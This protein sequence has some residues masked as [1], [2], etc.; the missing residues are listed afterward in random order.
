MKKF[1]FV[2]LSLCLTFVSTGSASALTVYWDNGGDG[3]EWGDN[4]NWNVGTGLE[5]SNRTAVLNQAN[6]SDGVD[7]HY[8]LVGPNVAGI[9]FRGAGTDK[10]TLDNE[11]GVRLKLRNAGVNT[12]DNTNLTL[13][14]TIRGS[15]FSNGPLKF[16]AS[17]TSELSLNNYIEGPQGA[18]IVFSTT[19]SGRLFIG[20]Y[21][22]TYGRIIFDGTGSDMRFTNNFKTRYASI[23][24]HPK[25]YLRGDFGHVTIVETGNALANTCV[26]V[27]GGLEVRSRGILRLSIG[28]PAS[29]LEYTRMNVNGPVKL[30]AGSKLGLV[31]GES[32]TLADIPVGKEMFLIRNDGTDRVQGRFITKDEGFRYDRGAGGVFE[33]SYVGGDGND[34]TLT[35]ISN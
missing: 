16:R 21:V 33:L 12:E 24:S 34:V 22:V 28:G 19:D 32:D 27:N 5:V 1:L 2:L 10:A 30:F 31:F 9:Y 26:D 20:S 23:F 13:E 17:D 11:P 4:D 6:Y 29:C 7:M 3:V 25:M 18:D 15:E 8:S 14:A 35:K